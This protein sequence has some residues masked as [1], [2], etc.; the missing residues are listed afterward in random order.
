MK[1]IPE[2]IWSQII[3][4]MHQVTAHPNGTAARYFNGMQVQTAAKTGTAQIV[5]IKQNEEYNH[6]RTAEHLRDHSLFVGFAPV[7]NPEIVVV[8]ILENQRAS[9]AV[10]RQV[11]ESYFMGPPYYA[12]Q[13]EIPAAS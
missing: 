11:I 12:Q 2:A 10:G 3:E 8:I 4:G 9:A 6:D 1:E 5:G 13:T 7:E